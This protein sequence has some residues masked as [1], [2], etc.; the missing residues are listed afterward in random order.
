MVCY[1]FSKLVILIIVYLDNHDYKNHDALISITKI[2][3][4]ISIIILKIIAQHYYRCVLKLRNI[5]VDM[6]KLD[7]VKYTQVTVYR[8]FHGK[9]I[10]CGK[11]Y[12]TKNFH[13]KHLTQ[14]IYD[15]VTNGTHGGVQEKALCSWIP[16]L[17]E[18]TCTPCWYA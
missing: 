16:C 4:I 5:H 18:A 2:I 12:A 15:T 11:F 14:R 3:T 7:L 6:Y 9:N 13:M 1:Q 8:N 17:P 10:S